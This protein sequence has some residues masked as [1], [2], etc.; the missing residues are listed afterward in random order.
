MLLLNSKSS[1]ADI[2]PVAI[3]DGI[4]RLLSVQPFE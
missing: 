4:R 3:V 2:D 1:R